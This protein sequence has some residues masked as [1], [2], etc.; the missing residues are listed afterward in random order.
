MEADEYKLAKDT[1]RA[2]QAEGLV[3]SELLNEAFDNLEKEYLN[4]W[5]ATRIEDMTGREKLF[6]AVNVIGK[7]KQHLQTIIMDGKL[8]EAQLRELAETAERKR[9]FGII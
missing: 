6:L 4:L 7:V 9:R 3:N 2:L 5:R 8:A 1:A